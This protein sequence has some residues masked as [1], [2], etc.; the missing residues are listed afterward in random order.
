MLSGLLAKKLQDPVVI[1]GLTGIIAFTAVGTTALSWVRKLSYRVFYITHV[2]LATML[3]P[4]LYFHVSQIHVYIYETIAIYALHTFLR[5]LGTQTDDATISPV[6]GT[7]LLRIAIP[8]TS[9]IKGRNP[10][11]AMDYQPGQHVYI[12]APL[13]TRH[14][15]WT[16]LYHPLSANPFT[17]A[18]IPSSDSNVTLIA[19]IM[20]GNTRAL[21]RNL[22]KDDSSHTVFVPLKIEG[23]YGLPSHSLKLLSYQR[24]LFIA[25]GV[26]ATFV[27]PLFRT[28]LKDLSPSPGSERRRGVKFVWS[29]RTSHETRWVFERGEGAA[30]QEDQS[31]EMRGLR[32]RMDVYV[33]G[34]GS[35]T[36]TGPGVHTEDKTPFAIDDE[37]E[38]GTE[39]VELQSL[40]P[41]DTTSTTTS[42]S[43][44][45]K[46]DSLRTHHGRPNLP[47]LMQQTFADAGQNDK[48]AVFVCGPRG[49]ARTVRREVGRYVKQGRDVWF[50][51]EEFGL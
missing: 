50:W 25:G 21:S 13:A 39:G 37:G 32:E 20:D 9:G 36:D 5:Y 19:R 29:V 47:A 15:T 4:V 35:G 24:I 51:A 23:P 6:P 22:T 14:S 27:V 26:G 44:S 43:S 45:S 33:T 17:V 3:L 42:N 31:S 30:K 49:M 2:V 46:T 34:S 10:L 16:R 38:V 41:R 8:T 48:I 40:L 7:N 28:L 11:R 12:S 18:S 1:L